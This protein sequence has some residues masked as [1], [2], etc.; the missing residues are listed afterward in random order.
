VVVAIVIVVLGAAVLVALITR[1]LRRQQA[2]EH[3]LYELA[4]K[5]EHQLE[6]ELAE[7]AERGRIAAELHDVLGL[8]LDEI[9]GSEDPTVRRT[10]L[11]ARGELGRLRAV[12]NVGD[13]PTPPNA[14]DELPAL[15]ER[16]HRNGL[17]VTLHMD[18]ERRLVPPSL[19]AA[20]YRVVQD[21]LA[22]VVEADDEAPTSVR[23]VWRPTVLGVQVRVASRISD[24]G[25]DV[26]ALEQRV[27]LY[28][29]DFRAGSHGTGFEVT[30]TLPLP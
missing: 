21:A 18:G 23:V 29:G 5:H 20:A 14:L 16:I 26:L 1:I 13:D 2:Q 17:P 7:A 3:R 11:T 30:A 22:H 4:V 12:L 19:E 15:V 6:A 28:D 24:D 10:A 8:L 25:L 9:A 27:A